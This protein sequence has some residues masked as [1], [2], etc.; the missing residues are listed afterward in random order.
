VKAG[1]FDPVFL[2]DNYRAVLVEKLR[3]KQAEMPVTPEAAAPTR[4]NVIDLMAA[5][6]RS[7]TAERATEASGAKAKARSAAASARP[8]PRK[9]SS[10]RSR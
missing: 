6:T 7:L 1:E 10:T 9:R 5:L 8:G 3:E 2:E 4:Q